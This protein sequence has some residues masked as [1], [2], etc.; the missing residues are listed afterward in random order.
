MEMDDEEFRYLATCGV[1]ILVNK[2]T[3]NYANE[4]CKRL[5]IIAELKDGLLD[6][7]NRS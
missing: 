6:V 7:K 4:R 3:L 2:R 5:G 1:N